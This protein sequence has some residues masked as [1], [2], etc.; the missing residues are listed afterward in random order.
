MLD[1][2]GGPGGYQAGQWPGLFHARGRLGN[3]LAMES[4]QDPLTMDSKLS[5]NWG[6]FK[7][8]WG[9]F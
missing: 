7:G 9:S 2:L 3:S 4:T 1:A 8:V 6:S 5:I